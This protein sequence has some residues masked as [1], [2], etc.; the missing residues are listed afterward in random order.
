M[1][2]LKY[3]KCEKVYLKEVGLDEKWLQARIAEDPT[4]VGL[5][6][7]TL[8]DKERIQPKGRLDLLLSDI[9][10][11]VRFVTEVQ[12]G[13]LDE[14]HIIRTIEY[15]DIER[16][17]FPNKEHVAVVVAEDVTS[18]YLNVLS[19]LNNSIPIIVLQLDARSF[20]GNIFLNF[21]KVLDVIEQMDEEE[22]TV[23]KADRS[24]WEGNASKE[25]IQLFDKIIG[26]Y[27]SIDEK[28]VLTFNK[29]HIAL[30]G[31]GKRNYSWFRPRKSNHVN[32]EIKF[33]PE[34]FDIAKDLC[35]EAGFEVMNPKKQK[36]KFNFNI[37]SSEFKE[38]QEALKKLF[39]MSHKSAF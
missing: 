8:I 36:G 20:E 35:E 27:K 3:N 11:G 30:G 28:V 10:A 26:I 12:L 25:S 19:L 31:D 5:G 1:G 34:E 32:I 38:R 17:R 13:S 15:W 24:Y 7:L 9:E 21:I 6:E 16:K 23:E 14:S 4:I 18:R 22:T 39:E 37:N 2:E 33:L 29:Y